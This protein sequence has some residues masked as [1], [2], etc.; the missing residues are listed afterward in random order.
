MQS[1]SQEEIKIS[2]DDL[3]QRRM[4]CGK[5]TPNGWV[6]SQLD[7]GEKRIEKGVE[8]LRKLDYRY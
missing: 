6:I 7:F 3:H 2:A 8:I 5:E 4:S 1:E